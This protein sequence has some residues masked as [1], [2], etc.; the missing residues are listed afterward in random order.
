METD[1]VFTVHSVN[2]QFF[3]LV[4]LMCILVFFIILKF[5]GVG[6]ISIN[7]YSTHME[8]VLYPSKCVSHLCLAL[9]FVSL[10]QKDLGPEGLVISICRSTFSLFRPSVLQP[11]YSLGGLL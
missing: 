9:S 2:N 5:F 10:S 11:V 6:K 7:M 8:Q 4:Y 3:W 1:V